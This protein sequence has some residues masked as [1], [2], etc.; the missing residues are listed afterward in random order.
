MILEEFLVNSLVPLMGLFI[1]VFVFRVGIKYNS[2]GIVMVTVSTWIVVFVIVLLTRVDLVEF[3]AGL[4]SFILC[5]C[6]II[7]RFD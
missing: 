6:H 1:R 4:C 7:R 3:I 5:Y 2:H